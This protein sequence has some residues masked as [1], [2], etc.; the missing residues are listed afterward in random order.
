PSLLICCLT[1]LLCISRSC[2]FFL[3]AAPASALYTLSLH[4]ALPIYQIC[5]VWPKAPDFGFPDEM[6]AF[7]LQFGHGLGLAR[8]AGRR[9]TS[10]DRKSTRLNSSHGS[11]SY[12]VFCLKKKKQTTTEKHTRQH[13]DTRR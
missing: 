9:P 3:H 8:I 7:G 10:R 11:I 12:A 1:A 13:H 4:A 2:C 5:K 6:S